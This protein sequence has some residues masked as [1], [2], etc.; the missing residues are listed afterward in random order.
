VRLQGPMGTRRISCHRMP[1]RW[2]LQRTNMPHRWVVQNT[3]MPHHWVLQSTHMMRYRCAI[4]S[5]CLL[6]SRGVAW[7]KQLRAVC[8][9]HATCRVHRATRKMQHATC[10]YATH[11]RSIIWRCEMQRMQHAACRYSS[12]C[13]IQCRHA[14]WNR[15]QL[16][17]DTHGL[18]LMQLWA[19][20]A[21]TKLPIAH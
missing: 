3:H 4:V 18:L 14:W 13:S 1:H 5:A 21:F 10:C 17:H 7:E 6:R 15:Y 11:C 9:Q 20:R 12:C 19:G 8:R 2:V 16:L